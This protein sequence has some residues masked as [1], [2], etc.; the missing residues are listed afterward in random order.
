MFDVDINLH[1][2]ALTQNHA[3]IFLWDRLNVCCIAS[4]PNTQRLQSLFE[5]LSIKERINYQYCNMET[6]YVVPSF[7]DFPI[8]K[9]LH[10]V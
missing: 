6:K 9:R 8:Y 1:I 10:G 4:P 5:L 7:K 3:A 2:Y